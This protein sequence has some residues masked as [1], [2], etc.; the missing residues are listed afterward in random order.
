MGV[1]PYS[2]RV[3]HISEIGQRVVM[4]YPEFDVV[5]YH[6]G[7]PDGIV[8]AWCFWTITTKADRDASKLFRGVRHGSLPPYE[9]LA[10]KKVVIVDFCYPLE[11]MK[12][13]A[14][15]ADHLTVLDH[16]D[17]AMRAI[18][19][20]EG[21]NVT[22]VFDMARSGA[23]IA[24]DYVNPASTIRPWFVEIVADRDLWKW[25]IPHSREYG[26][27]LHHGDWYRFDS[28]E[29]LNSM[30]PEQTE[31]VKT[32]L[33][34]QG[35]LL[36]SMEEKKVR[37]CV[38][39]SQLVE[40]EG[41]RVRLGHID[42]DYRSAAGNSLNEKGDCDFAA[43]W[44]YVYEVDQWWISVRAPKDCPIAV[45]KLCEKY[46]GG[47]HPAACGFAIHGHRSTDIDTALAKG[48]LRDYFVPL[49]EVQRIGSV[50]LTEV[51]ESIKELQQ[52]EAT[53]SDPLPSQ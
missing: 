49:T 5:L 39:Y 52:K 10:G 38:R 28:I 32:L 41:Y 13:I 20:L 36:K 30:T 44:R 11:E 19:K 46:G 33:L 45:N 27:A 14:R 50:P 47:G 29:A 17:T 40:F 7:C 21:E 31:D 51:P 37:I 9:L 6:G 3:I 22:K 42:S 43:T 53:E 26:T 34:T 15:V 18:E 35:T 8:G 23:Q 48:G 16:H 2:F 12:D 4:V 1:H 24:W 25:E